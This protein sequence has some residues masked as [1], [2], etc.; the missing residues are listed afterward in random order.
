VI[1]AN[2]I[3]FKSILVLTNISIVCRKKEPFRFTKGRPLQEKHPCY[4]THFEVINV[5]DNT[6]KR[7]VINSEQQQ[8]LS[9]NEI[10]FVQFDANSF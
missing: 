6:N 5:I 1:K 3:M 4:Q 10:S 9:A 2:I 8:E 7:N